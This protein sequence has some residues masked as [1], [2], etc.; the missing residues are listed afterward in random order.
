M[1][2]KKDNKKLKKKKL[3]KKT[4]KVKDSTK[5]STTK[6]KK[7]N[8]FILKDSIIYLIIGSLTLLM[9][10]VGASFAYF[11]ITVT[12]NSVNTTANITTP[13]SAGVFYLDGGDELLSLYI[14]IDDMDKTD[15][16]YGPKYAKTSDNKT[17]A[18]IGRINKT[19]GSLSINYTCYFNI[20]VSLNGSLKDKITIDDGSNF[21]ISG[22]NGLSFS[23]DKVS[24]S[25]TLSKDWTVLSEDKIYYG[26]WV[27]SNSIEDNAKVF[28]S[29]F[30]TNNKDVNQYYLEGLSSSMTFNLDNISCE[31]SAIS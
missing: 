8:N 23:E 25:E 3:K 7:N 22:E 9:L 28:I 10:I 2:N 1:D 14:S 13:S 11:S 26:K 27:T 19:D 16:M 24:Y 4:N 12:G 5:R 15:L 20:N 30:I 17:V 21:T 29:A 31:S 18:S 6:K